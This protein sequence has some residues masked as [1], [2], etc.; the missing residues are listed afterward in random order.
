M[1]SAGTIVAR[2]DAETRRHHVDADGM[3]LDLLRP[4]VSAG[5]YVASLVEAYGF[6][7]PLELAWTRT[8]GLD[9]VVDPERRARAR[10]IEHDLMAFGIGAARTMRMPERFTIPEAL[11]WMYVV[12][13]MYLLHGAVRRHLGARVPELGRACA[14]LDACAS[15]ASERWRDFVAAL[16]EVATTSQRIADGIARGAHDGFRCLRSWRQ[17]SA[18]RAQLPVSSIIGP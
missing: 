4:G 2:L 3:W 9:L 7:A 15:N 16:D 6:E 13:R 18:Q 17:P 12:E 8:T 14:Y 10:L 5:D 11:G 1:I